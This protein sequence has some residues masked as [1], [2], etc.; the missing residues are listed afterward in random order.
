MLVAA[1][2]DNPLAVPFVRRPHSFRVLA[3]QWS[4]APSQPGK[5]YDRAA[6][7]CRTYTY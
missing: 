3:H 7:R 5:P 4:P 6:A 2:L 1:W